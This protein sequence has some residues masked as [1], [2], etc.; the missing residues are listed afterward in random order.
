MFIIRTAFWLGLIVFLLPHDKESQSR[1]AVAA[2]N[3][4]RTLSTTCDRHPA[5]CEHGAY[6]WAVFKTNAQA[7]GKVAFEIA[8]DRLAPSTNASPVPTSASFGQRD[9]LKV[10]AAAA[11]GPRG[12]L[13]DEDLTPRW[14]GDA[15]RGRI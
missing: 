8:M 5:V 14:R 13:R 1:M 2:E 15:N 4:L 9:A 7:V 3:S 6:A 12:T 10:P 11:S